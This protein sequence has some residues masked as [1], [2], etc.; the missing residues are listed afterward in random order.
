[1]LLELP[2]ETRE[3][4]DGLRKFVESVVEPEVTRLQPILDE[5]HLLYGPDGR[6]HPDVRRREGRSGERRRMPATT[7]CSHRSRSEAA[8]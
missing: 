3:V 2:Q 7:R 1:M 4:V 5:P 8:A 6:F